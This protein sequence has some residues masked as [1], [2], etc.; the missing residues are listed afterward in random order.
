MSAEDGGAPGANLD[1]G[2]LASRAWGAFTKKPVEL[3]VGML[4]AT[5]TSF[6]VVTAG[7]AYLGMSRQALDAARGREVTIGSALQGYQRFGTALVAM[8]LVALSVLIGGVLCIV[9]GLIAAFLFSW[10][11][12]ILADHPELG[13]VDAMK[14]SLAL[15]KSAP[16]PTL[17]ALAASLVLSLA[18]SAVWIGFLVTTPLTMLFCAFVYDALTATRTA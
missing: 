15:A 9:P 12:M 11:F 1:Y 5:I 13:A 3:I 18:G 4:I 16:V 8:L 2:A 17:V 6:L 14:R 10:T 7:A